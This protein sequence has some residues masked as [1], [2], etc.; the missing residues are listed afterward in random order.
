MLI[1]KWVSILSRRSN[2]WK[3]YFL[4]RPLNICP[5]VVK[6]NRLFLKHIRS[7]FVARILTD[8]LRLGLVIAKLLLVLIIMT[9]SHCLGSLIKLE[10]LRFRLS[11]DRLPIF[12]NKSLFNF[13]LG[14]HVRKRHIIDSQF[15]MFSVFRQINCVFA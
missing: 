4:F 14:H 12:I 3:V 8:F 5:W 15:K 9:R 1:V 2:T 6:C 13:F 10:L 7:C 11:L